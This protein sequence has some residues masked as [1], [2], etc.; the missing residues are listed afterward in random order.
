MPK[1]GILK[2]QRAQASNQRQASHLFD[3]EANS[4]T[5]K[6][7]LETPDGGQSALLAQNRHLDVGEPGGSETSADHTAKAN[8]EAGGTEHSTPGGT[9]LSINSP[10]MRQ[11]DVPGQMQRFVSTR[12]EGRPLLQDSSGG[13]HGD[14]E[15]PQM[16]VQGR[17]TPKSEAGEQKEELFAQLKKDKVHEGKTDQAT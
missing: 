12:E 16:A 5:F 17:R 4:S 10:G 11:P 15:D 2:Q 7:V 1:H 9:G 6:P 13:A 14:K 8:A 3:V